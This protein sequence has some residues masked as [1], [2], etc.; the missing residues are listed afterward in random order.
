MKYVHAQY[1]THRNYANYHKTIIS[2]TIRQKFNFALKYIHI[3]IY[4]YIYIFFFFNESFTHDLH[5]CEFY[6]QLPWLHHNPMFTG[7]LYKG[8]LGNCADPDQMEHNEVSDQ[9]LHCT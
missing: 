5:V 2:K 3:Y 4:I 7:Y 1:C 6:Y 8:T 9:G